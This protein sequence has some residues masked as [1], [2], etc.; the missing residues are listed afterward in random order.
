L[1]K[2]ISNTESKEELIKKKEILDL[3]HKDRIQNLNMINFINSYSVDIF[4]QSGNSILVRG[5]SDKSWIY[6]SSKSETEYRELIGQLSESDIYLAAVEDWMIPILTVKKKILWNLKCQRFVLPK[7][8]QPGPVHHIV[9]YLKPGDASYIHENSMYKK[10]TPLEY[11]IDRI[12]RGIALGLY[13]KGGM[14]AWI[15]TQD[16]GAIGFLNVLPEFRRRGYG[17]DITNAVIKKVRERGGI[18]FV[19]IEESNV[20][21]I[22]LAKKVGFIMDKNVSWLRIENFAN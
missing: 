13:D 7:N 20:N 6:I 14:V 4:L 3:L 8:I 22:N 1:D 12:K 21:S 16:D 2:K 11:I 5:T 17:T 10:Y 19:H 9:R 18:P 15:L